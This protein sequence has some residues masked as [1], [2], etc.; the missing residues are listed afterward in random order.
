[1]FFFALRKW[2]FVPLQLARL[3][4]FNNNNKKNNLTSNLNLT[5]NIQNFVALV[6]ITKFF[7]HSRT[8]LIRKI[9]A[10]EKILTN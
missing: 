1:M 9:C 3:N 4:K 8:S 10:S 7:K 5:K 6:Q 2:V